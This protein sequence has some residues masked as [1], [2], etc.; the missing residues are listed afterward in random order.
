MTFL[1]QLALGSGA[2]AALG[3]A[4]RPRTPAAAGRHRGTGRQTRTAARRLRD[5]QPTP[6]QQ[7]DQ[8]P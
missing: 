2:L 4:F 1:L 6:D 8:Q 5:T 7:G 3:V